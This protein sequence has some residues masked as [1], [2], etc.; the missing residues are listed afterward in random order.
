V[1]AYNC[2]DA[3]RV[4]DEGQLV[5]DLGCH[6]QHRNPKLAL[7]ADEPPGQG[8]GEQWAANDQ[9]LDG[10]V[11]PQGL[12]YEAQPL[13]IVK[14]GLVAHLSAAQAMDALDK[15]MLVLSDG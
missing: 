10:G 6:V 5:H 1:L 4:F 8:I 14:A 13:G 7:L 9:R 15:G 2:A 12:Q 11:M 3:L